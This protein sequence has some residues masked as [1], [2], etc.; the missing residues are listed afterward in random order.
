MS[1]LVANG[2]LR[3]LLPKCFPTHEKQATKY[4]CCG[5][6]SV[7]ERFFQALWAS[8]R[9]MMFIGGLATASAGIMTL[10]MG[11]DT[12]W[13]PWEGEAS[14]MFPAVWFTLASFLATLA[15]CAA[16]VVLYTMFGLVTARADR[17]WWASGAVFLMVY[18]VY[19]LGSGTPQAALMLNVLHLV[20]G[21]PA[22]ILIP[23]A[24]N[25]RLPSSSPV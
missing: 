23:R 15:A 2:Q 12:P 10:A 21:V 13:A 19:S 4:G 20:V 5:K 1:S 25:H 22:L 14:V 11:M 18:G 3:A 6:S 16:G 9:S 8:S 24:I 7:I 17:W